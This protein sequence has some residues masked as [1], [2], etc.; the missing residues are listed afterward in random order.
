DGQIA[1]GYDQTNVWYWTRDSWVVFVE[2]ALPPGNGVGGHPNITQDGRQMTCSTLQGKPLKSEATIYDIAE[3][4]F[5]ESMGAVGPN[6][7]IERSGPWGMS[8]D[9]RYVCGLNWNGCSEARGFVR[10]RVTG[11]ERR[12]MS[13]YFYKPTR[14][15]AVSDDGSVIAGWADD[16]VGWRQGSVWIRNAAGEY[17]QS[18]IYRGVATA[19]C[20]EAS[21]VSGNGQWVFG[22]GRTGF[23]GGAPYR[24][25]VATG[26]QAMIPAPAG[27]GAVTDSNIDGS[28][29]LAI[30]GGS[31]YLW[32]TDRGYVSLAD[33][34]TEQ[35][36]ELPPEWSYTSFTM[37]DDGLTVGGYAIRTD[38]VWS[39]FVLNLRPTA[40]KCPADFDGDGTVG[41]ADLSAVL[42]AWGTFGSDV[43]L[44]GDNLVDA[45]D[46]SLLLA[47]WGDC[48]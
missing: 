48:P 34:S 41:A 45:A 29:A 46:L 37:S 31:S 32:F 39:P 40:P 19:K 17:V 18:L 20:S 13:S 24:W 4:N 12:M 25:S 8:R 3:V 28:M 36:F 26:Y 2:G 21:V 38:G 23:D 9:G 15:N 33:W 27:L 5:L 7:D 47:A 43:D 1:V 10:D 42:A 16:Y 6:C 14:A 35:G 30:F 22:R 44:D 11:E